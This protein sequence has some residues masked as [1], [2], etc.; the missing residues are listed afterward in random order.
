MVICLILLYLI[1]F[2]LKSYSFAIARFVTIRDY[3][4]TNYFYLSVNTT[5]TYEI[6]AYLQAN[7]IV[8]DL[9][10]LPFANYHIE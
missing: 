6:T 9:S 1:C 10:L 8:T 3:D 4:E 5:S 7:Q 2:L